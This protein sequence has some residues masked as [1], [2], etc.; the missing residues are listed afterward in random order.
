MF[1]R[2][3]PGRTAMHSE[4]F[5]SVA[6]VSFNRFDFLHRVIDSIHEHADMPFEIVLSDDGGY[7]Y[8][9]LSV[10]NQ[11]KDKV[12]HICINT[13]KNKGLA[14]NANMAVSMTRSKNVALFY[15]DCV[16]KRPFMRQASQVVE[17][18]PYIGAIYLGTG[19]R[20]A[21][22]PEA[23][24][25][26]MNSGMLHVKTSSGYKANL[27]CLHGSSQGTFFRKSY[28]YEVGGY[29]ED[30]IYG[31]L[32]FLNK[33]WLRGRF[34]AA[35]EGDQFCHDVGRHPKCALSSVNQQADNLFCHY[36]TLFNMPESTLLNISRQRTQQCAQ[37]NSGGRRDGAG[38]VQ[39]NEFDCVGWRRYMIEALSGGVVNWEKLS[40][41]HS[42]YM[43]ILKRDSLF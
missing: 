5:C 3:T 6:I 40:L 2:E 42:K 11:F 14:V 12:S 21:N 30:D 39:F 23:K 18:A 32:P 24:E 13:G 34:S 31:D 20:G 37:R 26:A 8:N 22:T 28:W 4:D 1:L 43:D 15:D 38:P 29:S 25:V 27:F 10:F 33:G 16:V 36:P 17:S 41:H 7:L 9:D 35:L 19:F